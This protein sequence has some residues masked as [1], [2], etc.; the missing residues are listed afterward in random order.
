M[1]EINTCVKKSAK[2]GVRNL[3]RHSCYYIKQQR[4]LSDF[5][6]CILFSKF[7]ESIRIHTKSINLLLN[8]YF[9]KS[10][11]KPA[12]LKPSTL[13]LEHYSKST[14]VVPTN[15]SRR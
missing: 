11:K 3:L 6:R 13:L 10:I 14:M 15:Y 1:Y 4:I 12:S 8:Y 2:M 5:I 9:I 7:C